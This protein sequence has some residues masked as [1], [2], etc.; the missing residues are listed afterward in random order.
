VFLPF[1][2]IRDLPAIISSDVPAAI[3]VRHL[4]LSG[5]LVHILLPLVSRLSYLVSNSVAPP[6]PSDLQRILQMSLVATTQARLS[7]FLVGQEHRDDEVRSTIDHLASTVRWRMTSNTLPPQLKTGTSSGNRTSLQRGPSLVRQRRRGW[8][9]SGHPGQ[10]WTIGNSVAV[11]RF[12]AIGRAA[13]SA[14]SSM[15]E[16][17][18]DDDVTPGQSVHD[19]RPDSQGTY[20]STLASTTAATVTPGP[21]TLRAADSAYDVRT[22]QADMFWRADER[23]TAIPAATQMDH[24]G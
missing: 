4:V 15:R 8:R 17:E 19:R 11:D 13:E 3:P 16:D 2:Q 10:G 6:L 21:S 1:T 24:R 14:W 23:G 18:D 22:P 9:I 7:S 5:F 20:A 12:D